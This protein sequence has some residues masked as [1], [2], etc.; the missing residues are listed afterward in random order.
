MQRVTVEAPYARRI[1]EQTVDEVIQLAVRRAE[2][3]LKRR[4]AKNLRIQANRASWLSETGPARNPSFPAGSL[5]RVTQAVYGDVSGQVDLAFDE[6]TTGQLLRSIRLGCR[7][8]GKLDTMERS[9]LRELAST[10]MNAVVASLA[11]NLRLRLYTG[12][13][14]V[15]E[16]GLT[17][18]TSPERLV[19]RL[20]IE[21][22][23]D[24]ADLL[25]TFGCGQTLLEHLR[26][27]LVTELGVQ[28]LALEGVEL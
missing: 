9:A 5:R 19:C 17:P 26:R 6:E 10:L 2:A 14:R 12:L 15:L 11:I 24:T 23:Q 22:G 28:L 25:L 1:E 27:S 21:C 8:R 3:R 16:P 4:T 18:P 7:T 13:P 20:S